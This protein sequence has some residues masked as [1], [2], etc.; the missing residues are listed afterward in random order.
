MAICIAIVFLQLASANGLS[1]DFKDII[2]GQNSSQTN[3]KNGEVKTNSSSKKNN[4]SS[5]VSFFG[6]KEKNETVLKYSDR[7]DDSYF[8]DA[9]FIGDSRTQAL[10][11]F[12]FLPTSQVF[13]EDGLNH[14]NARYKSFIDI[15]DGRYYT[16]N[17]ALTQ[18]NPNK[19]YVGFG[20]N[21]I[22]F[23][24]EEDFFTEYKGLVEDIKSAAPNSTIVLTAIIPVATSYES[25]NPKFSNSIIDDYN[26]K[27][28]DLAEELEVHY[29]DIATS[30][31]NEFNALSD[32]Y[33]A[34]DGIHLSKDAYVSIL[35]SILTH[36]VK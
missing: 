5:K 28:I 33:N 27:L 24:N 31:K 8:D 3:D 35:D 18:T 16:I 30:L 32:E 1:L 34:G 13:A 19:I 14:E 21:G 4:S 7:A 12:G 2:S 9:V 22:S 15:G 26:L 23:M 11:I 29:V 25:N 10:Q 20:I 17:S 6:N 36:T